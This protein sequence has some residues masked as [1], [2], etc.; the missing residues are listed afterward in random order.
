MNYTE[1]FNKTQLNI[2]HKLE[3]HDELQ[4]SFLHLLYQNLVD[5]HMLTHFLRLFYRLEHELKAVKTFKSRKT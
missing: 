4:R 2:H 1:T 3:H 5:K